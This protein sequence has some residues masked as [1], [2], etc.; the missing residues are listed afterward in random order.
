MKSSIKLRQGMD[1]YPIEFTTFSGG[2]VNVRLPEKMYLHGYISIVANIMDSDG[3][4]ALLMVKDALDRECSN[5]ASIALRLGYVPY[6]RQDRVCNPREALSIKVFCNIINSMNFSTVT[7]L[8]P[9][10]DVTSALLNNC[11]IVPPEKILEAASIGDAIFH[12]EF[13]L[14]A[15]D[16]GATKKVEKVAEYFG[17]MEVIQGTKKRDT[18]TG[19]LSGFGFIGDVKGKHLLIVDDIVD[20]GGT[21]LG[22]TEKLLE[23]GANSVALY[24]SH[25]IFAGGVERLLDNGIDRLYTTD[26]FNSGRIHEKLEVIKWT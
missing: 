22:L 14:V 21:F 25:G 1:E 12:G 17:G 24:I 23:G 8:D 3:V 9:H 19:E 18:K 2:E 16:T 4:M 10:S 7:I 26:S 11:E 15:P 5:V 20:F 6:A 13:T